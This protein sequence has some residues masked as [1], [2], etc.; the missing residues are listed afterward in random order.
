M[1]F[2][3]F[4]ALGVLAACSPTQTAPPS[5]P[6]PQSLPATTGIHNLH[7][8]GDK[9]ISGSAPEGDQGFDE[10]KS[11]G[12]KT[13]I[14]VDGATP[15]V[16]KA[17]ARGLRYVHIPVTYAEV[18]EGQRLHIARAIQDLPGPIYIHCHHGLHRAP[19][20]V[21]AAGVALGI[22]A[23]E[24]AIEYMKTA[25]TAPAYRG[26]YACVAEATVASAAALASA[27]TDYPEVSRA[28]G[29]VAA[30]VEI[31][32]AHDH[33][34]AIHTAGWVT[35]KDQPDLVPAADAGRLADNFRFGA[36]DPKAAARGD[37]FTKRLRAE[38]ENTTALEEA[39]SHNET[40][41]ELETRWRRVNN[42]CK[43]CHAE[44]RDKRK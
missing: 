33:L 15:D 26:L 21:A 32:D 41:A 36:E 35:P 14:S 27:S 13:I 25:G 42:S 1:R 31:D 3:I 5:D 39:L 24:Q 22:V 18:T 17:E 11:L 40:N 10:L 12:V 20:A 34:E 30:M 4:I 28:K 9:I 23:P 19:A 37:D 29:L 16:A 2:P 8:L 6:T 38:I 43:E 7:R 44:Y